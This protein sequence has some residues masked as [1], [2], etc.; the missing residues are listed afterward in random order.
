MNRV[1]LPLAGTVAGLVLVLGYRTTPLAPVTT[2][3]GAAAPTGTS[4]RT[5]TGRAA[6]TRWGPVQVAVVLAGDR[7]TQ[8]QVLQSPKG[9]R[10]DVEIGAY[11]LPL[12]QAQTLQV[13]SA[14]VDVVSGATYTSEGYRTSLQ[15]ALDLR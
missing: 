8:V 9:N 4:T 3:V 7:I 14:D 5:L 1:V 10:R 6:A 15:S 11:A 12:L 2:T 13:Q